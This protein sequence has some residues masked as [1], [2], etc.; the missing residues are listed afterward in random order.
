MPLD[1]REGADAEVIGNGYLPLSRSVK[2]ATSRQRLAAPRFT[3]S[4]AKPQPA[5]NKPSPN[6]PS[7]TPTE[8]TPTY[9]QS[10][11]PYT[12]DLT[13]STYVRWLA[14][15][16]C[17]TAKPASNSVWCGP[18]AVLFRSCAAYAPSRSATGDATPHEHQP[19]KRAARSSNQ[20]V[21]CRSSS[22]GPTRR[23]N[24]PVRISTTI[25]NNSA[26]SSPTRARTPSRSFRK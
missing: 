20:A 12:K 24:A 4:K 21:T 19:V 22:S 10:Q 26:S 18:T 1:D 7:S 13:G 6:S 25:G 5:G 2:Y 15:R 8:S 23:S 9:N 14:A 3:S 11:L 17:R 16:Q